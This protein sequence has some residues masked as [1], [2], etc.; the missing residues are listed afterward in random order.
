[1]VLTR[2]MKLAKSGKAD[3][4]SSRINAGNESRKLQKIS[5]EF[6][7]VDR[8]SD[9]PEAIISHIFF[10]PIE[11]VVATSLLSKSWRY[12]WTKLTSFDFDDDDSKSSEIKDFVNFVFMVLSSQCPEI[13]IDRFRL[14]LNN[15][16]FRRFFIFL[17]GQH[18]ALCTC[19]TLETLKLNGPL[20]V[21]VPNVVCLPELT[22]LKLRNVKF[23]SDESFPKFIS[24]SPVL[25]S[26]LVHRFHI[27]N[28]EV[29][30][31]SS[32]FL[33]ILRYAHNLDDDIWYIAE[34]DFKLE[35]DA[36]ALEYL[37]IT[38]SVS[39][40]IFTLQAMASLNEATLDVHSTA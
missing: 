7:A 2:S 21:Q 32:P 3:E 6:E 37:L 25:E 10:I 18:D 33:K 38:D 35:I 27:D 19:R 26:L 17:M 29:C 31:I 9:L 34:P 39:K 22:L 14:A 12:R 15:S 4:E 11:S 40:E 8:I 5:G 30:T 1:M 24:A 16:E 36:P 13:S 20:L 28:T 23:E